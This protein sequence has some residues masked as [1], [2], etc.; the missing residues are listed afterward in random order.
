[1]H[2]AQKLVWCLQHPV[3]NIYRCAILFRYPSVMTMADGNILVVGGAQQVHLHYAS[4]SVLISFI[5]RPK[6]MSAGV[7][8]ARCFPSGI[9]LIHTYRRSVTELACAGRIHTLKNKCQLSCR[10]WVAGVSPTL[11]PPSPA[12]MNQICYQG[13]AFPMEGEGQA[14]RTGIIRESSPHLIHRLS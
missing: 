3:S 8:N 2:A 5:I 13:I 1:M 4:G 7:N 9:S 12:T 10:R 11:Q 14:T 6:L